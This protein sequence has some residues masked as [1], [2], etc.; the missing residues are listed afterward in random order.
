MSSHSESPGPFSRLHALRGL[1][2]LLVVF[3]L[4]CSPQENKRV[5]KGLLPGNASALDYLDL[6]GLDE[7]VLA[8]PRTVDLYSDFLKRHPK[9]QDLPRLVDFQ[10]ESIL[11]LQPSLVL[12][13]A[14]Q[15]PETRD[16]LVRA[17]VP[18]LLLAPFR[19]LEDGKAN[20]KLIAEAVG[21]DATP[22]IQELE[23]REQALMDKRREGGGAPRVLPWVYYGESHWTAG[24]GTGADYALTL[25]GAQNQAALLGMSGHKE[26]PIELIL[27]SDPDALLLSDDTMAARLKA[28][29]RLKELRCLKAS[30]ILLL[31]SSLGSCNSPYLI[32]AAS[33]I[34]RQLLGLELL[35]E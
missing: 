7:D 15:S 10:A 26:I 30:R 24:T 35:Q 29:P 1:G 13:D 3:V 28:H 4:S 9:R 16:Y 17:G 14:T 18:V 25:A 20:L 6:L 8:L 27:H 22:V 23:A 31:R 19:S 5:A 21:R 2:L 34:R 11:A 32:D 12:S 33:E